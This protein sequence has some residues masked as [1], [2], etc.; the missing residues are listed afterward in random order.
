M[1]LKSKIKKFLSIMALALMVMIISASLVFGVYAA[2]TG[3]YGDV[4]GDGKFDSSDLIYMA[5]SLANWQGYSMTDSQ[6]SLSDM[7]LNGSFNAVDAVITSR[8]LAGWEGYANIPVKAEGTLPFSRGINVNGLESFSDS[9]YDSIEDDPDFFNSVIS[10]DTY[11]DIKSQGFDYV[12]LPVNLWRAYLDDADSFTTEEFMGYVDT[13]INHALNNGL[14][15]MLDFHGWFQIGDEANDIE[16]C[17]YIWE[18]VAE[19]YKDYDKKL[20]FELL[21]EPWYENSKARP[22]LSD[23][24]LN[25]LQADLISIIRSKGSNNATRLIVC[26][27]ADGNKAWKLSALSLPDDVNLA[28]AIHEYEPYNFTHQNFSWAGLSGQ[29]T[30]LEAAGGFTAKT[31]Y[32]FGEITKF[33][34]NT[35]IPVIL[36]EFGL[37]LAKA[38]TADIQTYINGIT[39]FCEENNIPWA[40]W[41]YFQSGY[42]SEGAMSLYRKMSS[43]WFARRSWDQTALDAM[44]GE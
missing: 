26:C 37:N 14:Y 40:Y 17:K 42:S 4:N 15:V 1:V 6:K 31:S 27:T 29:T 18:Q 23:S 8:Y 24:K 19:R 21:N 2:A 25:Q 20:S 30:T 5:R 38:S 16:E 34:K 28:V 10:E 41:Q 11:K 13:A 22:Y 44:F 9:D 33:M 12:R 32:D 43:S 36:N 3:T 7:D 39:S 35:G